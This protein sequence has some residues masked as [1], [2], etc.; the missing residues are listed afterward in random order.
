MHSPD[1]SYFENGVDPD[2]LTSE[3]C[4][5]YH[6]V[7]GQVL[8]PSSVFKFSQLFYNCAI[9]IIGRRRIISRKVCG[10]KVVQTHKPTITALRSQITNQT[11]YQL[12]YLDWH[13]IYYLCQINP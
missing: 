2:Q 12:C 6:I 5:H 3:N 10:P 7:P 4:E 13:F 11:P 9:L 1:I 8:Q